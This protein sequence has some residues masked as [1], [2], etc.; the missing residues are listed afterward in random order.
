MKPQ[1]IELHIEE[2]VLYGFKSEDRAAIGDAVQRELT[3]LFTEGGPHFSL[4]R[5]HQV[6]R[7]DGGTFN[8]KEGSNPATIG[9]HIAQQVYGG[10]KQ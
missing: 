3:R 8:V 6:S 2:L 4:Q 1:N 9:T 5:K 7:L 10:M